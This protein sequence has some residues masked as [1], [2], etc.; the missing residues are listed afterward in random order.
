M[1]HRFE[2]GT[3]NKVFILLHGTGGDENDLVPIAKFIDSSAAILGIRGNVNENG[4]NRY[5]KRFGM[6]KY[7]LESL[8]KETINLN[9]FI[10]DSI[11]LYELDKKDI[12]I[13]GFSNGANIA[14]S[15]LKYHMNH[16]FKFVLLSPALVEP[17]VIYPDLP[18][19]K[20]F[21]ATSP[22]DPYLPTEEFKTLVSNLSQSKAQIHIYEHPNGH[23]ITFDVLNETKRWIHE[24]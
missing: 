23:Q 15:L 16:R 22:K 1:I 3:G 17:N 8:N 2:K 7:D 9:Q 21:I 10:H 18:E 5:F 19:T 13:I 4:M 6:G 24:N 20:I 12:Y 11:K 14:Q